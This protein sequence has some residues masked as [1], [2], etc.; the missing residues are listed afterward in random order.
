MSRAA[1]VL[2]A[3]RKTVSERWSEK[4]SYTVS[5]YSYCV[6]G[7]ASAELGEIEWGVD[8]RLG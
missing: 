2:S 7:G 8:G 3:G 5:V 1:V 4:M 6:G